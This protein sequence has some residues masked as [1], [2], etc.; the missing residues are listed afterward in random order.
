MAF[1]GHGTTVEAQPGETVLRAGLRAG[2]PLPYECASGGCGSCRAQLVE[3]TVT[4]LWEQAGGLSERDRRRGNRVLMCQSVPAGPCTINAPRVSIPEGVDE[5]TPQRHGARLVGRQ[6]LTADTALFTLGVEAPVQYLP[7]QFM[8]LESP[9]GVRR[10]Y[11]MAHPVRDPS[12]VEFVIRAKPGGAASKWL[13][14]D[15]SVGDPL[16]AEGPY[17]RA[18]ARPHSARPVLC[19]A[20]GTGLAPILAITEHLLTAARPPSLH[21]YVGARTDTDIVLLDRLARLHDMGAE[22]ALSVEHPTLS[23][24]A[25]SPGNHRFSPVRIGRVIDHVADDWP[26]LQGHDIYLAGPAGMVDAALRALVRGA[27]APA[28]RVFFDRFLA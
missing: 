17:G 24:E 28:D 22:L 15:M 19:V 27:A 9:T 8:L 13:F 10:A 4:T 3:G 14:S 5:P 21:L 23:A 6:L 16:V 18:Y 7:G 1:T 11:S 12:T 26:A 25:L 2:L 20:G